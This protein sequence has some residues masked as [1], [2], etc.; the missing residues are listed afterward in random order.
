LNWQ[1]HATPYSSEIEIELVLDVLAVD[2]L[3][4]DVLPV[5]VAKAAVAAPALRAIAL[6]ITVKRRAHVMVVIRLPLFGAACVRA[7]SLR[8]RAIT[9]VLSRRAIKETSLP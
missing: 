6:P 5:F 1:F 7:R 3:A 4:V 2:V 8:M 9:L